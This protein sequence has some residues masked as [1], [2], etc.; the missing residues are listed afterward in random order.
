[1]KPG[2]QLRMEGNEIALGDGDPLDALAPE[3]E[4]HVVAQ[5]VDD[6]LAVVE[7]PQPLGACPVTELEVLISVRQ[8]LL[9]VSADHLQQGPLHRAI[10]A[11]EVG[12]AR[13]VALDAP[14][15]EL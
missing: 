6:G 2:I 13:L 5:M 4:R 15:V 3:L 14:E 1:M 11:I 10:R 8:M 12:P 7:A 9:V